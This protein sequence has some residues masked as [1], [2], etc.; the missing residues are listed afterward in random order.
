ME[1]SSE[2]NLRLNVLLAQNLQ[3]VRIDE[4]RMVVH[5]LSEK[6]EARV[7]LNPNGKDE[8]Y[9]RAVRQLLSSHVL[10]SPGGYPRY[11]KRWTRMGQARDE[12]LEKL[13]LLGEPEALSAVVHA[14]G[15]TDE[16]ARRAWWVEAT[17]ENARCMLERERVTRRGMGPELAEYLVEFLP[18]EGD[19]QAMIDSIRLVLRPGLIDDQNRQQLWNKA[20]RRTTYYVGFLVAAADNLPLDGMAHPD[21]EAVDVRLQSLIKEG[22]PVAIQLCRTLSA[23]GQGFLRVAEMALQKPANQDVVV[24]LLEAI[25]GYFA[26]IRSGDKRPRDIDAIKQEVERSWDDSTALREVLALIPQCNGP[27]RAMLVLSLYSEQLV[28]PIF[29]LTDA[30]GTVM[31]K[32]IAPI[33]DFTMKQFEMLRGPG[34]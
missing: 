8:Q 26:A 31:R 28:A 19:H 25:S 20:K 18:F 33:T 15:L 24:A 12:S 11:L 14:R 3:A 2:D 10:G 34:G 30:I 7:P 22:N 6:G 23:A 13:L 32:R 16:L 1:L 9:L 27:L 4:S 5:A 21:W 29:G 17:A